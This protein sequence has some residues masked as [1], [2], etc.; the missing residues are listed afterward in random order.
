M[1]EEIIE[2]MNEEMNDGNE[3]NVKG[4]K[5]RKIGL[6]KKVRYQGERF[7]MIKEIDIIIGLTETKRNIT[8]YE[9]EKNEEL[10]AYI[11]D[12]IEKIKKYYRTSSLG[13]FTDDIRHGKDNEVTLMKALY[14]DDDYEI[15]T[16][17]RM[18]NYDGVKKL[19]TELFFIKKE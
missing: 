2:E 15:L 9:L 8:L 5:V 1:N 4:C 13:Y 16:K 6:K 12:N 18:G 19:Y 11:R 10:R 17:R 7:E 14:K 3:N